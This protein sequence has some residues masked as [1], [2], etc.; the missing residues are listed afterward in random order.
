MAGRTSRVVAALLALAIGTGSMVTF[1]EPT[2]AE[3]ET[4]RTLMKEGRARRKN[5]DHKGALEAFSAADALMH[6]PTTGFEVGKEQLDLGMLV[7]A[8][9]TFLRVSRIPEEPGEP[10]PFAEARKQASDLAKEIEPRIPTLKLA[11]TGAEG[12]PKVTIDGNALPKA[13]LGLPQRLNPGTHQIVAVVGA[14]KRTTSVELK[15]SETREATLDL[16][17]TAEEAAAAKAPAPPEEKPTKPETPT[18]VP[19]GSS[20]LTWIGFGVAG[21]G[22]VVGSITGLLAMSK[23]SSAKE[24]CEG[25]LC[26]PAAH[27]DLASA[28]TMSTI[29]TVS[30]IVA[31]VGVG[32]GI[33][34][35][36][37]GG[38]TKPTTSTGANFGPFRGVTANVGLGSIGLSGN[39]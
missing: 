10:P 4:A 26:P 34:G 2:A 16:T 8:R 24:V 11:V 5:G 32:V 13:M 31:G 39:F 37:A 23:T 21:A 1:A 6:V 33:Y 28:R 3:K 7:E 36:V 35:L 38:S 25:N 9:D 18:E 12:E 29:S 14:V 19:S 30:F 27:D 17:P 22:V 20:P 15:E